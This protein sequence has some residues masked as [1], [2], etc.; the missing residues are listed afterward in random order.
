MKQAAE[1]RE[2]AAECRK[3]A[4]N[5]RNESE[6]WQLTQMAAAWEQMAGDR[7]RRVALGSESA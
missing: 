5:A 4:L 7:E 2:H 6:R 3:L 1:Y